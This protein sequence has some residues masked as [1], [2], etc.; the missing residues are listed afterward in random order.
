MTII[1]KLL[2]NRNFGTTENQD[3][4]KRKKKK[5]KKKKTAEKLHI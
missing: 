4:K 2:I 3:L 1:E 5:E